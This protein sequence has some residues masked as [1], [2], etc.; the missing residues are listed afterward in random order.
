AGSRITANT[1]SPPAMPTRASRSSSFTPGTLRRAAERC[2][3]S[4]GCARAAPSRARARA[5]R[6]DGARSGA[7]IGAV[8]RNRERSRRRAGRRETSPP[9]PSWRRHPMV[10]RLTVQIIVTVLAGLAYVL[11]L[12]G[13]IVP[14]LPGTITLVLATLVW[15]IVVGGW[16]AWTAFGLVLVFGAIGMGTSY[17][18]TGRRLHAAEVPMWPVY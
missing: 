10:D 13:I 9:S 6:M 15:A 16:L 2:R 7:D 1:P 3:P 8:S 18:L 17:V 14:V 11:G 4:P 12:T 5:D